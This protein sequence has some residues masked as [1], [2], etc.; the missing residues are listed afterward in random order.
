[1]NRSIR[2]LAAG[3]IACYVALFAMLNYW[4]VGQTEELESQPENTRAIIREFNRPRGPI[5]TADDVVVARSVPAEGA[6][7]VE[8]VR[9]YP[10]GDLFAHVTGYHT[11]GLG[12]TQLEREKSSVLTG[13]TARQ[14]LLALPGLVSG[15]TDTSGTVQLTLR[16]DLQQVAKFL[17]GDREG[18]IV[19]LDPRTGAVLAM[20]SYPSF[21]PNLIADPDY[22]AAFEVL[23]ELQG[24]PEDPLL[25]NAYMQRYMPGSTYKILTTGIAL[26]AGIVAPDTVFETES[27]YVP[28]QTD[29][30][31]GNYRGSSCGGNLVEVFTRS[32]NTPFARMAVEL[33]PERFIEGNEQ[34]G[35]G[36]T[37][38]IDL[39]RAA[40][41]TIGP[42][43]DLDQ[44]LP[45]L[46]M[47]GFGQN[48]SQMVPLHMAMAAGTVANG[49]RMMVPHVVGAEFDHQGRVLERATSRVWKTPITPDTASTMT[50]M[51]VEVATRGTASC[52]IGLDSG[53]PVAAKTGT[54]QLN[55]TG[56][57]EESHAWITAFAPADEPRYAVAVMLKGTSA[58]I[59]AGT[60]G[61]LAGPIAK[62]M[63]DVIFEIEAAE[64][65]QEDSADG[66]DE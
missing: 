2:H 10:T 15:R 28:P 20:W 31:V 32:C 1:M 5:V 57:P 34:W 50:D 42:T 25:A 63:L 36:E 43:D 27:E 56:E 60:G 9:Q 22:D 39:P 13:S 51:M 62:G 11:F 29:R 17:L 65:A 8:F 7:E 45:L 23:T 33:G 16:H 24:D 55:D 37:I 52:C 41:S 48:E 44:N 59:S 40:A 3:L 47:R 4:Q 38:P 46:A 54:A 18:S 53:I 61:R 21:D 6:S 19:V 66:T 64:A 14:Q 35:V 26:E 49:G 30:P 12:A 58:E